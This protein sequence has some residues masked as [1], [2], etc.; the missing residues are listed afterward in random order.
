MI[1]MGSGE[2]DKIK[3][4]IPKQATVLKYEVSG[5]TIYFTYEYDGR[6]FKSK[7]AYGRRGINARVRKSVSKTKSEKS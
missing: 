7:L 2:V 6:I 1:D 4:F 5:E 3:A